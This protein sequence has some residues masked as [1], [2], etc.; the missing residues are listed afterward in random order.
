MITP[1]PA[2]KHEMTPYYPE[3][4]EF[5]TQQFIETPYFTW[6]VVAPFS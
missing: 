5:W 2:K 6:S 1:T 3:N 4:N